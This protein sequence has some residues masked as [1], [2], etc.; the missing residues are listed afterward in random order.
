MFFAITW[1]LVLTLLAIWSV[2]VW[3][4]HSLVHWSLTGVGALVDQP[5]QLATLPGWLALWVP[6]EWVAALQALTTAVVP[7]VESVLSVLP[8][9]DVWL[10][11][12]AWISWGIGLLILA[13]AGLAVSALIAMTR[14]ASAR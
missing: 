11:P 6:P 9:A 14:K 4:M 3:V 12:L 13:G 2:S 8:S 1:F 5:Q 7:M 10:T